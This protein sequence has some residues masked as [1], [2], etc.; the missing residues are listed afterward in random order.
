[1][2]G[3]KLIKPIDKSLIGSI[4][5]VEKKLRS[6]A[7]K[8]DL[9][10]WIGGRCKEIVVSNV[11]FG[12]IKWTRQHCKTTHAAGMLIPVRHKEAYS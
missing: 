11:D 4:Y 8:W 12:V 3:N 10:Y 6:V 2:D 9:E 1:M 5:V 7:S